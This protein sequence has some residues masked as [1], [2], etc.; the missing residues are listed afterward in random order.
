MAQKA[1]G[2]SLPDRQYGINTDMVADMQAETRLFQSIANES[3]D[4]IYVVR[5]DNYELLY[6]NEAKCLF[7]SEQACVGKKCYEALHGKDAP[8]TFCTMKTRPPDGEEHEMNVGIP[9]R[10]YATRF[11]ETDWNGVAAY[12]KY[13][14]DV[15][16]E[17]NTRREKERLEQYFQTLVK[18]LPGGVAVVRYAEY[19]RM[20]PEF[21]SDGF[22]SMTRMTLAEAW[23]LYRE[24][25]MAGVHPADR[26]F[27]N[28]QMDAYLAG[29][30]SHCAIEY[31]LKSGEGGYIWVQNTLSLIQ[32]EGGERRVYAVYN[33]ISQKRREREQLRRQYNDLLLQHY[34]TPGPNAIIVGHC[35]I[36]QNEIL[37]IIDYT[38]SKLLETFGTQRECFFTGLAGL[39]VSPKERETFLGIYLNEPALAAFREK[40]TQRVLDCFIQLPQEA[41][42]RYVQ[43]SMNMV[44]TPDSGDVT[45]ILTITDITEQ[46]VTDR[47]LHRLS[48]MG[49]DFVMDL[50]LSHDHYRILACNEHGRDLPC[51][52]GCHTQWVAERLRT[53]VVPRDREQYQKGLDPQMIRER[54]RREGP[55]TFAF[56]VED[57]TGEIR[58]KNITISE[59][60]L[61]LGRVCLV[62]ADITASVRQQQGLLHVIAYTFELAGFVDLASRRLT[63]YTQQTVQENLPPYY[64]EN[65]EQAIQRFVAQYAL[66][67]G[68]AEVG[69]QFQVNTMVRNL[70]QKPAGYD[71][72]FPYSGR[73]G[74]RYKQINVMW[75]DVNHSTICLV[76]ADVT[77]MVTAERRSRKALED[78]LQSAKEA[79]RAKSDFLSNMSHDI[80][81]P[82]NAIMG[83]TALAQAHLDDR[84][85]VEDCLQKISLS[86]N[87]LLSLIN[88]ILDMS[89]IERAQ[90][91]LNRMEVSVPDLMG[92]LSAM[93]EPQARA[94]GVCLRLCSQGVN[95]EHFYG[96]PLRINQVLINLLSNAVKFTPEGGLVECL[97]QEL[98]PGR[99]AGHARYRFTVRDTGVGMTET[100]LEHIFEP[101]IRS[102]NISRVEGTGLG[103][104]IV[105]GLVDLMDGEIRVESRLKEGTVC[106]VELECE[107]AA[108]TVPHA[109]EQP[110]VP[111]QPFKGRCFL[112]AEDNAINAEILCELLQMQ[113]ASTVV[114]SDGAQAVQAFLSAPPGAYDAVLMDIQM[115]GM[116]GYEATRV[117]RAINRPDAGQIP[118][119]AMTANAFAEDVQAAHEAG[120][121]AHVAKPIDMAVLRAALSRVLARAERQHGAMGR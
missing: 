76:R 112:V 89:K 88:D 49:Y 90:L 3:A 114:R 113:G 62:R 4:G 16:K 33:D 5:K 15:T 17:V 121:D 54:L 82:M 19:G 12:V 86:S 60:D 94:A 71:F 74:E 57:E 45:G 9:G 47:I 14:R 44:S 65:Y 116:N 41:A 2:G 107:I 75:G 59:V 39:I 79:N 97:A 55:Y 34:R 77:D 117:I 120:M 23:D 42:G 72:L 104:S 61:R 99:T 43:V 91:T 18:N 28:E 81:T 56:S 29:G 102:S 119:I 110:A 64:L 118:I 115:P 105:K 35:N 58:T 20:K 46:I 66:Q 32:S 31:R 11:H 30:A 52:R 111:L 13:V 85:R 96:D 68:Q 101:F 98:G 24:D 1:L 63:L 73:E 87:H 51:S 95:H 93:M 78:A 50:D 40:N 6:V 36:T 108:E 69:A 106:Q 84:A 25:A 22:A 8:C 109:V 103:L 26:A 10:F 27:V 38:G 70:E 7:A 83:M 100:F 80:R 48:V 21:L 92:Q 53:G 37:E 67:E